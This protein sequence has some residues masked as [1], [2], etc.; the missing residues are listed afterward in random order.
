MNGMTIVLYTNAI[1]FYTICVA[2]PII[3]ANDCGEGIDPKSHYVYGIYSVIGFVLEVFGTLRLQR[4]VGDANILKF[5]K[6]HVVELFM[7]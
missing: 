6:W 1:I 2:C 4:L 7:G 5:N 3:F